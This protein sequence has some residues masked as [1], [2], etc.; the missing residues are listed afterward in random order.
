VEDADFS[1]EFCRFIQVAVPSVDAAELLL[2][3]SQHADAWWEAGELAYKLG[4]GVSI[5]HAASA[6]YLEHFHSRGLLAVGP[7][8]KVQYR[9]ASEELAAFVRTLSQA[10]Q[11]RPVT[12]IRVI[13]AMRDAKVQSFADAFKLRR[14]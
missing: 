12:L 1:D 13:Y 5:D 6:R 4:P 7:D 11:Q 8:R 2:W 14:K 9:P 3:L 10:Y